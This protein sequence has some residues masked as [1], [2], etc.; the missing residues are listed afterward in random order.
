MQRS[1]LGE[2]NSVGQAFCEQT[3]GKSE[4]EVRHEQPGLTVG[5][6]T[7]ATVCGESGS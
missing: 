6:P 2:P 1:A 4:V 7:P 3:G 5:L